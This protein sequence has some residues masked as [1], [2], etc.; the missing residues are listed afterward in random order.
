MDLD[1]NGKMKCSQNWEPHAHEQVFGRDNAS[2]NIT[3]LI[4]LLIWSVSRNKKSMCQLFPR[5]RILRQY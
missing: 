5:P 3:I 1:S 2:D 4:E